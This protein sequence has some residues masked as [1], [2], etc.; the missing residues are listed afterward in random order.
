M[1][2]VKG[3]AGT[4]LTDGQNRTVIMAMHHVTISGVCAGSKGEANKDCDERLRPDWQY[5]NDPPK[6]G[7]ER[8]KGEHTGQVRVH[9]SH[10]QHKR[11]HDKGDA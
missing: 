1:D 2:V 10:W 4:F 3:L 7:D 5:A 11:P 9:E 6:P 8:A